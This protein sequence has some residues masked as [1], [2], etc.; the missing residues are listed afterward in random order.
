[1]VPAWESVENQLWEFKWVSCLYF[2]FEKIDEDQEG[3]NDELVIDLVTER[4]IASTRNQP[5][6]DRFYFGIFDFK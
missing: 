3:R 2:K 1:M 4:I 5:V 6:E